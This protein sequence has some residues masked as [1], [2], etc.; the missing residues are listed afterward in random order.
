MAFDITSRRATETGVIDLK[1]GDGGP[2]LDDKGDQLSVTVHGPGS[3]IWQQ[4]NAEVNRKRTERIRKAGGK[5]TA[6]LD[7]VKDDQ[8]EF[9]VRIT[10]SFNGWEYPAPEKGKWATQAE[11]FRAAYVDDTI[12]FIRDHVYAEATDWSAFT[13][14]S[15][16]S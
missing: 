8:I 4:A 6:A 13:K 12:G 15:A 11:M 14:G 10:V 1:D 9:L 5:I 16:K 7:D 3:K 2:L